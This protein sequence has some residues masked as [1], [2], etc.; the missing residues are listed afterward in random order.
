MKTKVKTLITFSKSDGR[1]RGHFSMFRGLGLNPEFIPLS[2][3]AITKHF[4]RELSQYYLGL[5]A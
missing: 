5:L 3:R 2:G 4:S 1:K